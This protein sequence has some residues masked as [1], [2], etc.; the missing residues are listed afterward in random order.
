MSVS[1]DGGSLSRDVT[2]LTS[3]EIRI[4]RA[5]N[6]RPK[7]RCS[8]TDRHPGDNDMRNDSLS[9]KRFL[10]KEREGERKSVWPL[11]FFSLSRIVTTHESG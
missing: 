3:G 9:Q 1:Y 6:R 5:E 7:I 4:D 11:S 2:R 8:L 10:E